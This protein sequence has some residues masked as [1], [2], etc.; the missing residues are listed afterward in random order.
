MISTDLVVIVTPINYLSLRCIAVILQ[1]LILF[2]IVFLLCMFV[3]NRNIYEFLTE[4]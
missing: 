4:E 1:C 2:V 3:L